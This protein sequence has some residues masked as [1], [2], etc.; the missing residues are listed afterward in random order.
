MSLVCRPVYTA[1]AF[2]EL[3]RAWHHIQLLVQH[4]N[5]RVYLI[6]DFQTFRKYLLCV[7]PHFGDRDKSNEPYYFSTPD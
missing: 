4:Y 6:I 2:S 1:S 3:G 5:Y 7:M